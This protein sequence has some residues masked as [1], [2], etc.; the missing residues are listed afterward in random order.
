MNRNLARNFLRKELADLARQRKDVVLPELA[1]VRMSD[2]AKVKLREI[3]KY[4]PSR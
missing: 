4:A 3:K 1:S 2:V